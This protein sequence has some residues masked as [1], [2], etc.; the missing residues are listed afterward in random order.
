MPYGSL[1]RSPLAERTDAR[2]LLG[3]MHT[4]ATVADAGSF[5][6]AGRRLGISRSVVSEAI[7]GL[8]AELGCRLFQRTTR[9]LH[10]TPAGGRIVEHARAMVE[11]GERALEAAEGARGRPGGT[12][13][14]TAPT[15]LASLVLPTV[16]ELMDAYGLRVDLSLTDSRLDVL[17][18]RLDVAVRLGH[19]RD[20][21][22]IIR[23]FATVPEVVCATPAFAAAHPVAG[24]D[25]LSEVPWV[26]HAALP[27]RLQLVGPDSAEATVALEPA[28]SCD[29]ADAVLGL[30]RGGHGAGML[31]IPMVVD[32]LRAGRLVRLLPEWRP[33][34]PAL[35]ALMPAR[36]H[37]PARTRAFLDRF[38]ERVRSAAEQWS[39]ALR[40]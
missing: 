8:E 26:V 33:P 4:F 22:L 37:V 28:A 36:T 11:A 39:A 23:R 19:P 27:R 9:R 30:V 2:N 24:P 12:L 3:R 35:F 20:S 6:A 5:A 13:R 1:T 34:A 29:A 38:G 17:D 40:D 16:G 18:A 32:G 25:A 21:S 7:A 31:P 10:L 15:L 14:L